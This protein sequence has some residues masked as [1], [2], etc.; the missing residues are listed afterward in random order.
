MKLSICTD[1]MGDLL[2]TDMLDK[3]VAMGVI[4]WSIDALQATISR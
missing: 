4:Q 2:F 1:V 3:R